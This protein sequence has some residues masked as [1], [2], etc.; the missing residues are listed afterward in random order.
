MALACACSFG[1]YQ[2]L[3]PSN[4]AEQYVLEIF[5]GAQIFSKSAPKGKVRPEFISNLLAHPKDSKTGQKRDVLVRDVTIEEG[6]ITCREE[7]GVL[8]IDNCKIEG[9]LT[10]DGIKAESIEVL[11]SYGTI[12]LRRCRTASGLIIEKVEDGGA[13]LQV[14]IVQCSIGFLESEGSADITCRQSSFGANTS[15]DQFTNASAPNHH[16]P[17]LTVTGCNFDGD[18]ILGIVTTGS[19]DLGRCTVSGTVSIDTEGFSK[20]SLIDLTARNL[21]CKLGFPS[22]KAVLS[23]GSS[24]ISRLASISCPDPLKMN[25]TKSTFGRGLDLDCAEVTDILLS[26]N[27]IGELQLKNSLGS[28]DELLS[29]LTLK[30]TSFQSVHMVPQ[31]GTKPLEIADGLL[32]L[33]Y[34]PLMYSSY[35]AQLRREGRT[36]YADDIFI[37]GKFRELNSPAT[38]VMKKA[39]NLASLLLTGYGK[40]RIQSLLPVVLLWI[41]GTIVFRMRKKKFG[42]ARMVQKEGGSPYAAGSYSL[43]TL[44]PIVDLHISNNW[45]PSP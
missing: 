39:S 16:V 29:G 34:D 44:L 13:V 22:E 18:L 45:E 10:V 23:I 40:R 25:L 3:A 32:Q 36:D 26:N 11:S 4:P 5:Q 24:D 41:V 30:T 17:S 19:I 14:F 28:I 9:F 7:V 6:K 37:A 35:E 27:V 21:D 2:L 43:D 38:S 20:I 1:Q 33:P 31:S 42:V 8:K 12:T 15:I